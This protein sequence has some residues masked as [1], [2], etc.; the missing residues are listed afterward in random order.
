[1]KPKRISAIC[2]VLASLLALPVSAVL[3]QNATD[4]G[5]GQTAAP[6]ANAPASQ[7]QNGTA[8][9]GQLQEV[10]VTAERRATDVQ[11]TPIAVT[12]VQGDQLQT[13][14]LNTISDLQTTVPSFQSNDEAG[15]FNS[16]NIRG[17]GNSAITPVIATGVAVFRDGLLMSETI[18]EDEPLFD[19]ADTEVL[20]G[21]QGTFVGASSTAGAVE[22]NSVN[23]NFNGLNGYV[24]ASLANYSDTKWQGAINLPVTDT[25]AARLAFNDEQRN[26]FYNDIGS[27]LNG[28]YVN[29]SGQIAPL[30]QGTPAQSLPITDPGHLDSRQARLKL[31]WKPT[32]S[33]QALGEAEY[34]FINTGGEPGEPDPYTYQT[35]FS[36]GAENPVTGLQAGCTLGGPI[37][38]SQEVCSAPGTSQHSQY[39][40]PGEK[41]FVLD[42]YGTAQQEDELLTHYSMELRYTLS[43]GIVLRSMS[44][45]VHIDINH[46]DNNSYGPQDAGWTYHEIGPNDDYMSEEVNIISPTTGKVNW[47]AGAFWNYRDTPVFLNSLSVSA[48]YQPNQLPSTEAF[49][50][51]PSVN[52]IAAVFGQLGWQFTNTLQLQIGARENWDNNFAS[53]AIAPVVPGVTY[54]EPDGAGVYLLNYTGTSTVPS[55]YTAIAPVAASGQFKDSVPTGK[56][57]LNWTPVP[58]Q[59]F[60]AFYA[61]GYKSGG[62]N[63]GSTDHPYFNPEH[64]N[65]YELGWK[66]RVLDGHMLT[67]VGA[68][69]VNYQDMQY[70]LFDTIAQN[71]SNT[72]SYVANLA[73]STIYGLEVSEQSRFAGLGVNVGFDYTHSA[74]G[75]VTTLNSA[76][77]PPG[78]GSP[79]S[80]PQCEAGRSYST[81]CF[82]YV[83]YEVNVSGEENPFA[84]KVTVNVTVDYLFHVGMGTIDPR[85]TFSHTDQQYDSIFENPYNL[86]QARNLWNASV[87]WVVNKWDLQLFGTNLGNQTYIIAGGNPLYYGPPRQG[88]IQATYRF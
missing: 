14:H 13:L 6:P 75:S 23:P 84:P 83:P 79:V 39:Y 43:D 22:I 2:V 19:I 36:A 51:L 9:L 10:V 17:M 12:A 60:Y 57:D 32:D 34:S 71:D 46:Q 50:Q 11:T 86:M 64:V 52:R 41:P 24:L 45:F 68:Y 1:M 21:P 30:L 33:F 59:N 28:Y 88:G 38:A 81:T 35:L 16:I 5:G 27:T 53:N 58:G 61:R 78:F 73:A 67:Q 8:A 42:Y 69:Y 44:G 62:D 29:A 3:A 65:D 85:V 7:S 63:S 82:N 56:I 25:F 54:P 55:S 72:G 4:Q 49:L 40:Y 47:I 20:E 87:D 74:L 48:P 37:S 66:G 70:E 76:A 18:A 77:L 15:F 31:L 26:S 80:P